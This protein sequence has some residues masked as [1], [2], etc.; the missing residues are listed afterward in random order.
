MG[1]RLPGGAEQVCE[2]APMSQVPI[3]SVTGEMG[4]G[5]GVSRKAGLAQSGGE[6]S[7]VGRQAEA[8]PR[9]NDLVLLCG[10][11]LEQISTVSKTTESSKVPGST[12]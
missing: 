1:G 2:V 7:W 12:Q 4:V 9:A 11:R 8:N 5:E 6:R 10:R 3:A